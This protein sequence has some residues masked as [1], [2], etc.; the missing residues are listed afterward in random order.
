MEMAPQEGHWYNLR[1]PSVSDE[2]N[3][4]INVIFLLLSSTL[5]LNAT[6]IE[7][8]LKKFGLC[9]ECGSIIQHQM[10]RNLLLNTNSILSLPYLRS[11]H[12]RQYLLQLGSFDCLERPARKHNRENK[13]FSPPNLR[14]YRLIRNFAESV[15]RM[16]RSEY[17]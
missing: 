10:N 2:I 15:C 4:E 11:K 16:G 3:K 7:K 14:I 5:H 6:T 1:K 13:N 12:Q 17:C 8:V 9:K